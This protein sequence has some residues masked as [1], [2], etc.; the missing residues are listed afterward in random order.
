MAGVVA[1]LEAHHTLG[2]FG[3]PVHQLA[4]AFVAPLRTDDNHIPTFGYIHFK[5]F[6]TI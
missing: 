4:L 3:E 5:L 1:A 6:K 2:T